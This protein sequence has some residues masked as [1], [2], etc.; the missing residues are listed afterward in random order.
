MKNKLLFIIMILLFFYSVFTSFQIYNAK[1]EK[2][3]IMSVAKLFDDYSLTREYKKKLE[4]GIKEDQKYMDSLTVAIRLIIDNTASVDTQK[5]Y[6]ELLGRKGL[7]LKSNQEDLMQKYNQSI[8]NSLESEIKAFSQLN[9]YKLILNGDDE[10][11]LI[12]YAEQIDIT[13][14]IQLFI[15]QREK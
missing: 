10:S 7:E 9:D 4:D 6:D 11:M 3:G 1:N 14:Q 8:I 13:E 15:K 2:I 12:H 5:Y